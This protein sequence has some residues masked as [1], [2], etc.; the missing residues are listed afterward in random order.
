MSHDPLTMDLDHA[1]ITVMD[2]MTA[3]CSSCGGTIFAIRNVSKDPGL[4]VQLLSET[5]GEVSFAC[6]RCNQR[7]RIEFNEPG[8]IQNGLVV[9]TPKPPRDNARFQALVRSVPPTGQ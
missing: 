3:V 1:T 9:R 4:Q 7:V 6:R 8:P 5:G 2:V